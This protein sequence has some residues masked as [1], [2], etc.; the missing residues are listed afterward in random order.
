MPYRVA[1]RS[2]LNFLRR[3]Q[4]QDG[5]IPATRQG[6]PSGCWTSAETLEALLTAYG[7]DF[8]PREFALQLVEFLASSQ[9]TAAPHN[10]G[11]P[12]VRGGVRA[13]TMATGHAVAALQ[14]AARYFGDHE[15][16][17]NKIKLLVEVGFAWIERTRNPGGG[18]GV[19]PSGGAD[20]AE[21]RMISTVYAL[22]AYFAGGKTVQDS[23]IVRE[24]TQ[25]ITRLRN[26]DGGFAGQLGAPS[27]PCNTA[28]AV[29]ALL[30]S[31]YAKPADAI[32]K[33]AIKYIRTAR[34]RWL[35]WNLDTETYVTDGAPGQTVYN[36]NTT[37]D[38][39]EALVRAGGP[40]R[41]VDRLV[42]W[43]LKH[44]GVDGSW[45]LGANELRAP[46]IVTWPTNEAVIALSLACRRFVEAR[47]PKLVARERRFRRMTI[48]LTIV[49]VGE[50]LFIVKRPPFLTD[51]WDSLS[52]GTQSLI[53]LTVGAGLI[54]NLASSF[55][56]DV[57][58]H[59]WSKR[60]H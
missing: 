59:F 17:K 30:L 9:L 39:L 18:W 45:V 16:T 27:D 44:Q 52:G 38:V 40:D 19:E 46:E 23:S 5:G 42:R 56:Y 34:P 54:V 48:I 7:D 47:L 32:V 10:G 53:T 60:Q 8:D 3:V 58:R 2:G 25:A 41:L 26:T 31:E 21:F 57:F 6:A 43:Y 29:S 13:S 49:A 1:I 11:W 24:A 33:Q 36:S 50:L 22:H 12:L 51:W 14:I 15:P 55:L 37:A 4:N 20:G 35:L 28:R